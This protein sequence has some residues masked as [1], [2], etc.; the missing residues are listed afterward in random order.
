MR[1]VD[2]I[3]HSQRRREILQAAARCFERSGFRG[4]SI[5]DICAEAGISPG[6]LYHY[7]K[8]K[9]AI[10]FAMADGRLEEMAGRFDR[11][12]GGDE[13]VTAA[14]LADID[15]TKPRGTKLAVLFE[16]LA[17]AAR[18]PVFAEMARLHNQVMRKLL[19]DVLRRG[20]SR[21][22]IKKDLDTETAAA[23]LICLMDPTVM[24]G[25]RG[26]DMDT[27]ETRNLLKNMITE[28]L[29]PYPGTKQAVPRK[30]RAS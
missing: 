17:E 28:F 25:S 9:E 26:P 2:P 30:K 21:G 8:N 14:L 24:L 6:H 12:F 16:I 20:Q 22:E 29:A 5:A 27:P 23:L 13:S 1:K 4:A 15:F 18:N 10:V 19:A 3:K 11:A 7:F